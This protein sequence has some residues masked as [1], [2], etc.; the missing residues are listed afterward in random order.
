MKCPTCKDAKENQCCKC[1]KEIPK[2][3]QK[4]DSDPYASEINDDE[5]PHMQC[6][7]CDEESIIET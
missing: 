6:K 5:T 2:E 7:E 1:G 4:I 3:E